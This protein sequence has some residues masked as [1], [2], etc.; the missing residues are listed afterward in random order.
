[1]HAQVTVFDHDGNVLGDSSGTDLAQ[2]ASGA[3]A[4]EFRDARANGVG[5]AT[6]TVDGNAMRFVAVPAADGL[7]LRLGAPLSEID[8]TLVAMRQH[9]FFAVRTR[10]R[11]GAGPGMAR[12][13]TGRAAF[14]SDDAERFAHC[15]RRLR[16]RPLAGARRLRRLVANAGIAGGAARSQARRVD[17][18]ARPLERHSR[19]DG[20]GRGGARCRRCRGTGQP[21]AETILE[22]ALIGKTLAR[23]ICRPESPRANCGGARTD[24]T[25]EA[26]LESG[27]GLSLYVRPL[28]A[29]GEAWSQCCVT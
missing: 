1:M 10:H 29:R 12:V 25:S 28:A 11:G 27:R 26:E 6:R 13:A 15:S 19:R 22:N 17:L 5:R 20:G 16:H 9:L 4:P 23:A 3:G 7:V 21:A 14:A 2:A 24:Q 8:G 18:G